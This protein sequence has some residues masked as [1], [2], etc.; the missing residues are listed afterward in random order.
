MKAVEIY[1]HLEQ[2]HVDDGVVAVSAN[3]GISATKLRDSCGTVDD[4]KVTPLSEDYAETR[5]NLMAPVV[6]DTGIEPVTPTMSR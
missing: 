6:G 1:A 5:R 3:I 2:S 4:I